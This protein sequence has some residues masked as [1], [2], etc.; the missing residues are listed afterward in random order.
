MEPL[1]AVAPSNQRSVPVRT[2]LVLFNEKAGSVRPGDQEKLVEILTASGVSKYALVSADRLSRRLFARSN[3][4]DAIIVLGGDGTARAAAAMAPRN[5][6]PLILLPGGT[7][8]IL[9]KALY[10]DL[11]WP[12]ALSAAPSQ[13]Q[14]ARCRLRPAQ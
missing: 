5:G 3:E 7:L 12:E 4:Y 8:N 14:R 9:P 10:G 2:A 11:T 13:L 6:P 1:T